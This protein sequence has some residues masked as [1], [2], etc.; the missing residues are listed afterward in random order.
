MQF[1]VNNERRKVAGVMERLAKQ[2]MGIDIMK[3][4]EIT[5]SIGETTVVG[6]AKVLHI[7]FIVDVSGSMQLDGRMVAVNEAFEKM[8]PALQ[9]V[10]RQ[11]AS[12]FE[13]RISI[14]TFEMDAEWIVEPTPIMEYSHKTIDYTPYRT[15]YSSAYNALA[16][17]L[18][19]KEEFNGLFAF[20]GKRAEPYIMFLT[21]GF[22][23]EDDD[24]EPA[25]EVLL[26]NGWFKHARRYAV[27]IGTDAIDNPSAREAVS[28]FVSTPEGIIEAKDAT[29]IVSQ[30][31]AC[32]I[33]EVVA[34]MHGVPGQTG[35]SRT[36]D[37]EDAV[38]NPFAGM[39]FSN[40][41]FI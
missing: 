3:T 10:Q 24:Y 20:D 36:T 30:V 23:T 27:L 38:D 40:D 14:I 9:E 33:K 12:N 18:T 13:I 22:P 6:T 34:T 28:R 39:V 15:Y 1:L 32:T 37:N 31:Q 11:N 41:I 25:L 4:E 2:E 17:R 29:D 35:S 16:Q 21:D 7:V 19:S 8:I 5:K 26:N